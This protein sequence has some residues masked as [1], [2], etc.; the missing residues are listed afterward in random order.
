MALTDGRRAQEL[1]YAQVEINRAVFAMNA[2]DQL[3]RL[4]YASL[5]ASD[6]SDESIL[7][8]IDRALAHL[9][10]AREGYLAQKELGF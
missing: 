2:Q 7:Q 8:H 1:V 9:A 10:Q 3:E 6:V 4:E 5:D